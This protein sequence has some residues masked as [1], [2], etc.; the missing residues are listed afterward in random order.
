MAGCLHVLENLSEI[1]GK[2][3]AHEKI[4][5]GMDHDGTIAEVITTLIES[6][7][8]VSMRNTLYS[9]SQNP[10][11]HL[12][13]ISGRTINSLKEVANIKSNNIFY[14]GNHGFEIEGDKTDYTFEDKEALEKIKV[15][16]EEMDNKFS[17]VEGL[18]FEKKIF[19]TSFI[20][21]TAAPEKQESIR[22]EL[23]EA[24][25]KYQGIRI[26]EGKKL[27]NIRPK[28]NINKGVALETVGR[29]FYK[30]EWRNH[31]TAIYI[32]DDNSDEDAFKMLGDKDIGV[33]VNENPPASTNAKYYAKNVE[34]IEKFLMWLDEN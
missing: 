13:I 11:I 1:S 17:N 20:W 10:R 23:L 14:A 24:L 4:L 8:T 31:V 21:S 22:G 32:G 3:K 2:L 15:I 30:D 7:M 27:F 12:V 26:V 33:I 16:T 5:L 29:H 18:V 6:R 9:L 25:Q 34:E 19:T 28:V